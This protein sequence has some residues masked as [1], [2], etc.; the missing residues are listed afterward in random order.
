MSSAI[1]VAK[2]VTYLPDLVEVQRA[3]FKWFL[4]KGLIEELESFSPITDYTG[5]L[6]LHFIGSEYRLKRPRHDVEE[7]KRRDATFASQMYV[8][9]RL[10]NKETGE[11]KEQEVFI[12]EP[13][14]SLKP[15]RTTCCTCGSTRPAR[16]T[17]TC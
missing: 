6:E 16:S 15:T 12:G 2:T 13:G 7:A 5:K 17:P 10:V 4:E 8:T 9:C 1:Q 14:S 11:I 3:S